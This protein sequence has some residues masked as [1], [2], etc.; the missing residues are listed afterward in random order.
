[1]TNLIIAVKSCVEHMELGY[2]AAIRETWYRDFPGGTVKFFVGGG[3][4][5]T[6]PDEVRLDCPDD[7]NSL[8]KKTKAICMWAASKAASHIFLADTDTFIIASKLL[9]CGYENYD[10]A[11]KIDK[12]FGQ[13]FPYISVSR[14]GTSQMH[15]HTYPWASGGFGYFLSKKAANIIAYTEPRGWAEDFNTGQQLGPLYNTG[16]ITMLHTPGE[17]YSWHFPAHLYN[18]GYD[19]KFGWQHKMYEE[20]Q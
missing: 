15:H 12:P 13:A 14:E 11:G 5:R 10:Y 7:Y 20:H 6:E 17:V 4:G 3:T 19:L 2:H 8:P 16:E 9:A 18:S 1:M